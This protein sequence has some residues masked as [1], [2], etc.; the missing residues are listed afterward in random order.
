[1]EAIG[2]DGSSVQPGRFYW[3][4]CAAAEQ[5][6]W[7][8]GGVLSS[9][10]EVPLALLVGIGRSPA[11]MLGRLGRDEGPGR[12][13]MVQAAPKDIDAALRG[14]VGDLRR[15]VGREP[16]LCLVQCPAAPLDALSDAALT[17][18]CAALGGWCAS[19]GHRLVFLCH[20]DV[21][22]LPSRMLAQNRHCSGVAQL[23]SQFGALRYQLHYWAS[24]AGVVAGRGFRVEHTAQGLR[25]LAGDP[26]AEPAAT[27]T[28]GGDHSLH[29]VQADALEGAPPFSSAWQACDGWPALMVPA[30]RAQAATVV[31]AVHENPQV[32][33]LARLLY[34]LRSE[35]G[36]GLKLVVR[37]M[38]PC[39][40]YADERLLLSCGANLIVPSGTS[41]ARF[42]TLLETVQGE[43]WKGALDTD[44]E[45]LI[46]AHRAPEV[47]GIVG[48]DVF[49][50]IAGEV[51]ERPGGA[52]ESVVLALQPVA[53]VRI[54]Y[55][56]RQLRMRRRG[57]MVCVQGGQVVLF[58]FGCRRDGVESA[59]GNLFHLSW[60]EMFD[61]YRYLAAHDV[62]MLDGMDAT[63]VAAVE[64]VMPNE[65]VDEQQRV[66][67]ALQPRSLRLKGAA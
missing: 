23:Y 27:D 29:L 39:L 34:R 42:L 19:G 6:D 4:G 25:V 54:D 40:R 3:L 62:A 33:A 55:V 2:R 44:P 35:R 49:R 48:V 47:S 1:M 26:R 50:Q 56:L 10:A 60:R 59:L 37:E 58:L 66:S 63:P 61:G 43:R 9:A 15:L 28:A 64:A 32:D 14:L 22:V 20:G 41:L 31:F 53:G 36:N 52:V 7:L 17:D 45:R 30:L 21:A 67:T 12:T 24:D 5:A 38:Q 11:P 16:I 13:R 51:L 46:R 8:G 65:T 57:D 18:W